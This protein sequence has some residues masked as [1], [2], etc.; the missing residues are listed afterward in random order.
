MNIYELCAREADQLHRSGMTPPPKRRCVLWLEAAARR[1]L[2][3]NSSGRQLKLKSSHRQLELS[4][5][6]PRLKLNS[7]ETEGFPCDF[8]EL[9]GD[10]RRFSRM[11][12]DFPSIF[13]AAATAATQLSARQL[14]F[15]SSGWQLDVN[16]NGRQFEL[17]STGRQL[18]L[19]SGV[20]QLKL[21]SMGPRLELNSSEIEG[22]P[23]ISKKLL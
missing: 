9:E 4:S 8:Q 10:F 15:N 13:V 2:N 20:R 19:S 7:S 21:N 6:G 23:V 1:Q 14:K 18:K 5:N 22:S 12:W 3:W 11:S 17:N 16:S